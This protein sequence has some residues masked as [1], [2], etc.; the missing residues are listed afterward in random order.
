MYVLLR[1]HVDVYIKILNIIIIIIIKKY[2]K[3]NNLK[4]V[5]G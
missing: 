1:E 4:N 5:D 2:L 3:N